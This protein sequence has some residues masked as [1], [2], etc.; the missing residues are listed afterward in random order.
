MAST[1]P[2]DF[3]DLQSASNRINGLVN[4]IGIVTDVLP[5]TPSRGTDWMCTFSIADHTFGQCDN[6]LKVRFF[7]PEPELPKI[8]GTGDVV[9]LRNIKISLWSGMTIALASYATRWTVIPAHSIP[10]KPFFMNATAEMLHAISLCN[11][12]DKSSFTSPSIITPRISSIAPLRDATPLVQGRRDKFSSIKDVEVG[13]FYDLVGQVVKIY[14]ANGL[15]ELYITDYT[16][17]KLLFNYE[18]RGHEEENAREGDEFSYLPRSSSHKSWPGPFGRLTLMVALWP[19]HSYFAQTNVKERNFVYLRNVHIKYSK[20]GKVEGAMHTDTRQND[21]VDVSILKDHRDDENV[22]NVLRRKK[23][24]TEKF[25]N[26][27]QDSP[28]EPRGV[29]RKS[30]EKN[31]TLSKKQA[32][33]RRRQP[34]EELAHAPTKTIEKQVETEDPQI[35]PQPKPSKQEL[36]KNSVYTF[37]QCVPSCLQLPTK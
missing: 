28:G 34:K 26:K 6:G 2:R 3:V 32:R 12:H 36:N 7:K 5:I 17:N 27:L 37:S 30:A 10:Q 11:S 14:P 25:D 1:I 16:S 13:K 23:E 4:I 31:E 22:K 35:I 20:D 15:V 24:Y 33:R 19:A 9:V 29:K 21:R 8:H 18:R